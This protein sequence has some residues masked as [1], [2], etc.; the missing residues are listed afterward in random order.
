[1]LIQKT[2]KEENSYIGSNLGSNGDFHS[3]LHIPNGGSSKPITKE[4]IDTREQFLKMNGKET[5]KS[6]IKYMVKSIRNVLKKTKL[7]IDDIDWVIP[8]QA[9]IRIIDEIQKK[10]QIPKERIFINIEKYGNTSAASIPIAFNELVE[11]KKIKR[12]QLCLLVAFG[13]GFTWGANIIKY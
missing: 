1:M 13:G 11:S 4:N 7:S 2:D 8:H 12:G 5:F 9:N 3:F 10:L 6:A